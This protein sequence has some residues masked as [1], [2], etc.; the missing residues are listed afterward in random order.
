MTEPT[1]VTPADDE[2]KDFTRAAKRIRFRVAPDVFEGIP[3]LPAMELVEFAALADKLDEADV[4]QFPALFRQ[5]F[6][7]ILQEDSY[8]LFNKRLSDREHPIDFQHLQD[9][10]PWLLEE[11]GLR[12]TQPSS[13]SS[14]GS[15]SPDV[16]T[17]STENAQAVA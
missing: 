8:D 4:G 3:G 2:I 9:I 6:G 5:L 17:P 16:G 14:A 15:E 1:I 13:D 10:L 12:P 11:Y 7:M